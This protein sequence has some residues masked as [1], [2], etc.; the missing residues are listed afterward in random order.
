MVGHQEGG[1]PFIRAGVDDDFIDM[2][3]SNSTGTTGGGDFSVAPDG[4]VWAY[5][6]HWDIVSDPSSF[7]GVLRYQCTL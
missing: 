4:S 6:W 2:W 1:E 7:G 5:I 3:E